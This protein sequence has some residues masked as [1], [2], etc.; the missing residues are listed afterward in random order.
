VFQD[1]RRSIPAFL[2]ATLA[3][4]SPSPAL[5]QELRLAPDRPLAFVDA[6]G[7]AVSSADFAGQWLL[8]Y[9]GYTHCADLCPTGLSVMVSAL[10]QIGPAAQ[11]I[12]PLFITVDPER[13]NGPMLRSFTR[14]FDQRLIGLTGSIAQIREA[15]ST[16]GVSFERVAQGSDYTIDHSS[17]YILVDPTRTRAEVVRSAEPHTIAAKLIA[18]LTRAGV[19]LGNV[20]NVGAYR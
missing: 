3:L 12:Q 18:T 4:G 8:I 5:S 13:D 17:T 2:A 9:F 14:S 6:D 19:P 11:H 15:A 10:D 7:R 20:N 1:L 16:L